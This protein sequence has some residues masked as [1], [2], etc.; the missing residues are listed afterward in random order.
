M[1]EQERERELR[2][3]DLLTVDPRQELVPCAN[4]GRATYHGPSVARA[5]GDF[6]KLPLGFTVADCRRHIHVRDEEV[7]CCTKCRYDV[8]GRW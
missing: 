1:P 4:C 6:V 5:F 2:L 8:Y 7:I 3:Y